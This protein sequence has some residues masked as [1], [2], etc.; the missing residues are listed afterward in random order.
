MD[1]GSWLF[2]AALVLLLAGAMYFAAVETA[3][4]SVS[5]ARLRAGSE[6]GDARA[7]SALK[8]L[9]EFDLAITTILIGTNI[10]HLSAAAIVTVRVTRLY[11]TGAV[12]W[13][14]LATTVVL[15]LFGEMLP[16]S[17][18]KRCSESLCLRAAGSLRFFMRLFSPAARLLAAI[19][20][21]VAGRTRGDGDVSVTEDE[22]YDLIEDMTDDGTLGEK[23]GDLV[24]HALEFGDITVEHVLTARV[25]MAA[26]DINWPV[27]KI[28]DFIRAQRHSRIPVYEGS[29]DNIIGI[30]QIRR[31]IP[32]WLSGSVD[33]RA[34]LDEPYF[35]P[36]GT[37]VDDL[38]PEMSRKRMNMAIVTDAWGGTLGLVTV[39]DILEELVGEIWDEEDEV[40]EYFRP[41][42]GG[43]FELDARLDVQQAFAYLDFDDPED[44][45]E[46]AHKSLSEWT[47][48]QFDLMPA[49]RDSFTYHGLEFTISDVFQH[50]IR[51]LVARR[52][53][54]EE[55]GTEGGGA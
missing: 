44:N 6:K 20:R 32:A 41:L 4:A 14:T 5:R 54:A 49:Q 46:L 53:P 25:D 30:L 55:Q 2:L 15:F 24:Q 13:G 17:A 42:G 1:D 31:F 35:V 18:A 51:K 26:A 9:D 3:F 52:L 28:A 34:L 33:V 36:A 8:V 23:Q 16:K 40:E 43:R 48:E 50:R 47:L 27:E 45:D 37:N 11:G 29:Q 21:A 19:G 7:R 38:L 22:L 10:V 39:E 12:A